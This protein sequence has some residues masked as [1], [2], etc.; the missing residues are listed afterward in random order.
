MEETDLPWEKQVAE[1]QP[2]ADIDVLKSVITTHY[3]ELATSTFEL[4]N[5]GWDS[6]AVEVDGKWIF[7]FPREQDDAGALLYEAGLLKVFQPALTM[8]VPALEII[9]GPP[10]FS[11]HEKIPGGHLTPELYVR[12][13]TTTRDRL[14]SDLARFYAELHRFDR[15]LIAQAGAVPIRPWQ[16]AEVI[17]RQV[18]PLLAE[19]LFT[20]V[21]R[22][23]TEWQD[24]PADP[25]GTTYGFFDGHGW[26]MAFDEAEGKLNGIY[27]F[28]DSG[29]GPLHQD[30]IYS[31]WIS[32]DLTERIV[33]Q[34]ERLT[35]L[36]LDRR[37]IEVLSGV[38]RLS[39][40]AEYAHDPERVGGV[41]MV[42]QWFG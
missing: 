42:A 26:N 2:Q 8:R 21:E 19:P 38:I 12:L 27:D 22:T 31:N 15:K 1:N 23:I 10:M 14:A 16:P 18:H 40:L 7:K 28:A 5:Q 41:A 35:G 25:H 3:P 11:R 34:Y 24:Q 20:L 17:L 4:L 13:N 30:F 32:R 36:S 6:A 39:E 33:T 29:F 37:R 9:A